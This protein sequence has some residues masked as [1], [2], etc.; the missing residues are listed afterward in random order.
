ME[1]FSLTQ[2]AVAQRLS[3]PQGTVSRWLRGTVPHRK[4]VDALASVL[5]LRPEWLL[6]GE[7][8]KFP[9]GKAEQEIHDL[10]IPGAN[11][12]HPSDRKPSPAEADIPQEAIAHELRTIAEAFSRLAALIS[13]KREK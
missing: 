2:V 5:G 11:P 3:V 13:E 6:H 9:A 10:P 8:P 7:E 1:R 4:T 12:A